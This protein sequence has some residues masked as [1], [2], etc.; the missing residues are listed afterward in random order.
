MSDQA[1]LWS[2]GQ[3]AHDE[4]VSATLGDIPTLPFER[5]IYHAP[6]S[7]FWRMVESAEIADG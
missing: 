5:G 6:M 4:N 2:V 1:D 3:K 7:N